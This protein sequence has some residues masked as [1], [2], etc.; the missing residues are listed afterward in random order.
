MSVTDPREP[1][2]P[3]LLAI[4]CQDDA[5][6]WFKVEIMIAF[7]RGKISANTVKEITRHFGLRAA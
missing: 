1:T 5:R 4:R 6:A 7:H 3:D 2:W